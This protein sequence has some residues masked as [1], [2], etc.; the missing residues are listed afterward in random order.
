MNRAEW[1]REL[2]AERVTSSRESLTDV[3]A[4]LELER[5]ESPA[6]RVR[7]A[8]WA[9]EARARV[10]AAAACAR[11]DSGEVGRYTYLE[12]RLGRH[13]LDEVMDELTDSWWAA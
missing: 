12:Q 4:R 2:E 3:L 11:W 1:L 5:P 6:Q 13:R 8:Q 9:A 10:W 7:A